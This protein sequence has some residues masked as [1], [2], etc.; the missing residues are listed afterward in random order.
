MVHPSVSVAAKI[1]TFFF[2]LPVADMGGYIILYLVLSKQD[3]KP[4]TRSDI[5]SA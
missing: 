2:W 1:P 4:D 5:L 3:T